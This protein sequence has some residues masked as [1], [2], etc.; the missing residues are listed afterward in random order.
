MGG[1]RAGAG[2][3]CGEE[4]VHDLGAAGDDG[5]EFAAVDDL[6]G[7]GGGVLDQVGD[8]LDGDTTVVGAENLCHQAIFMDH[9]SGAVTS[10]DAEV[11]RTSDVIWQR[12]ERRGLVTEI[13]RPAGF[14]NE[15]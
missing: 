5:S 1:L 14:Q 4:F 3:G 6:G 2:L 11:V 8:L 7:A 10:L 9:S 13:E 12:A 15:A